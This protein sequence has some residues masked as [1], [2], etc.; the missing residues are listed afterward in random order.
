MCKFID[1]SYVL[2]LFFVCLLVKLSDTNTK[3]ICMQP[4]KPPL[5]DK[6]LEATNTVHFAYSV[7]LLH[8]G[9]VVHCV[10]PGIPWGQ[11]S[12]L[13]PSFVM[14]GGTRTLMFN[15]CIHALILNFVKYM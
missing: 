5:S 8:H 14:Q 1:P 3:Y 6:G 4:V 10:L 13:R 15:V 9:R 12:D 7:T 11:A 2:I